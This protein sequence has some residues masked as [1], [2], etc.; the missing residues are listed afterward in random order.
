[1][2][3]CKI[4]NG[5]IACSRDSGSK[6]RSCGAAIDWITTESGKKMPVNKKFIPAIEDP[7]GDINAVTES[8]SIVDLRLKRYK[9]TIDGQEYKIAPIKNTMEIERKH[10][11]IELQEYRQ[12]VGKKSYESMMYNNRKRRKERREK[13][14]A[15]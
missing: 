5:Y 9:I 15:S 14:N 4:G 13:T 6:C 11:D 8:I 10:K 2:M 3:G 1:M 7:N 12:T